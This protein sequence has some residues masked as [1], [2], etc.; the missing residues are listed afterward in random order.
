MISL[1]KNIDASFLMGEIL[2]GIP[3]TDDAS[4]EYLEPNPHSA[5]NYFSQAA[6]RGHILATHR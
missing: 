6:T 2:M 4:A 1:A 3:G 5:F